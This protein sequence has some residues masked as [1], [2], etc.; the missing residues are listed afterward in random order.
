MNWFSIVNSRIKRIDINH[1]DLGI[2]TTDTHAII[3][4]NTNFR[5]MV[6]KDDLVLINQSKFTKEL[7]QYV[8]FFYATE[9]HTILDVFSLFLKHQTD[10]LPV[11]DE[12]NNLIGGLSFDEVLDLLNDTEFIS[13]NTDTIL[14]KKEIANFSYSEITQT[15]ES[16]NAQI[17]GMFTCKVD[18]TS[19]EFIVKLK[20]LGL[21]EVLQTLRRY[22]Y[23][24]LSKHE[25]DVYRDDL[26][27]RSDYLT[28]F[29]N[30]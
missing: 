30:I 9:Y 18:H 22:E 11:L 3:T 6:Q 15:L 1:I 21:N 5:G 17:L 10:I 4:D 2:E 14:L 16:L 29:L 23:D 20:H 7:P 8:E 28:K 25:D 12:D 19:I 27:E 26:K 24:I 13:H